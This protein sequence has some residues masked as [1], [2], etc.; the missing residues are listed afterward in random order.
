MPSGVLQNDFFPEKSIPQ[1]CGENDNVQE[2]Y[3]FAE[4]L[5][6]EFSRAET[7]LTV[8]RP[9]LI[10]QQ[11]KNS[12]DEGPDKYMIFGKFFEIFSKS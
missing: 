11:R 1:I 10:R 6:C 5:L 2:N 9:V 3:D 4:N 7:T 8:Y 12:A